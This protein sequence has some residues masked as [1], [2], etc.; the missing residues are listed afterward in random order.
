VMI[1]F[2]VYLGQINDCLRSLL[3]DIKLILALGVLWLV[4]GAVAGAGIR[5][6]FYVEWITPCALISL[7]LGMS[8]LLFVMRDDEARRKLYGESNEEI[9]FRL[10]LAVLITL[11]VAF[12]IVGL[13]WLLTAFLLPR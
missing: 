1:E 13:V 8:L 7:I 3:R 12:L 5:A 6:Y 2:G 10:G 4:G 11:P 9:H